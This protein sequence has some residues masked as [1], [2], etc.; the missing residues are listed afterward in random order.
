[1]PKLS[2]VIPVYNTE[3]YLRK[4]LDSVCNQ[5]LQD[6]EIICVNDA[7]TDNSLEIL[8]EYASSDN[9]IK[10]INFPQNK[11]AAVARNTAIHEAKGEYIGFVDSDDYIDLD[12]YEKLYEKALEGGA[13]I[14]VGNYYMHF[15]NKNTFYDK[16]FLT[17]IQEN[18]V[19]FNGLF[20][21]A[22][23]NKKLLQKN[24]IIFSETYRYGE[25]RIF[26]IFAVYHSKVV[27]IV[28][29]VFYHI[30]KRDGSSSS[31]YFNDKEKMKDFVE[32]SKEILMQFNLLNYDK[33]SYSI[34]FHEYLDYIL[35]TLLQTTDIFKSIVIDLYYYFYEHI[36]FQAVFDQRYNA[37]IKCIKNPKLLVQVLKKRVHN[38]IIPKRIFYV[39]FGGKKS[40]L[41]NVC[42][43]NW[44]EKLQDFEFV[45][46]NEDSP[47]FDF[48]SE[49]K[50]CKW[51]REVYDRKLWAFASDY[52]RI[53]VMYEYGGI[54]L[55]TD[56]TIK[57]DLSP[58]LKHSF[59]IG[60]EETG[61]LSAG[62]FGA[63]PN[64][65]YLQAMLDFYQKDIY[66]S[67]LYIIPQILTKVYGDNEFD[68]IYV[69]PPEFFYPFHY[70][71]SYS[72]QCITPNT[73]TIH[74][75]GASWIN[76]SNLVF[77]QNKHLLAT[78]R[79]RI[80]K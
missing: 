72:P 56:I 10:V 5:T 9:R 53:R 78:L 12:F 2:V 69:Y 40:I 3:K 61:V 7:S 17:K 64:H 62:I 30:Q 37:K 57:K 26:P 42:I 6:I 21:L 28:Y 65:P 15:K 73:Y 45:E 22:I 80:T 24:N 32:S 33:D 13:D 51:F 29:D 27:E 38:S 54:Y 31:G 14:V 60:E 52:A 71:E 76:A 8:K 79:K 50:N 66:K 16:D 19:R 63:I 48:K 55:D 35:S 36:K 46:I 25:D 74:W 75:W 23:Y 44:Q 34:F 70:E 4:C 59:F 49:Y 41:A 58:L 67:P 11:G 68:D 77:L 18:K 39:W 47:Y 1:M 43:D 20:V